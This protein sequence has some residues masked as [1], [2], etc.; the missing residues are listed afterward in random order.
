MRLDSVLRAN[1]ELGASTARQMDYE[2]DYYRRELRRIAPGATLADLNFASQTLVGSI[3]YHIALM[4][5]DL[6]DARIE[7]LVDQAIALICCDL[8]TG[9]P[10]GE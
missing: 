6:E 5:I 9:R 8:G 2:I 10:V 3:I 4:R 1:T 7:Q